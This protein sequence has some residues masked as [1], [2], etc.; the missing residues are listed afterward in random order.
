MKL[1]FVVLLSLCVAALATKGFDFSVWQGTPSVADLE[2]LKHNGYEFGIIQAQCSNGV[3]NSHVAQAFRNAK[4]AGIKYVDLYFFP[5]KSHDAASQVRNTVN[6]LKADG[7]HS[8]STQ[9]WIDIENTGLFF[10]S[11]SENVRFIRE[12]V[13]NLRKEWPGKIG[14]YTSESQWSPITCNSKDFADMQLWWPRYDGVGTLTH[15]WRSF[16]GW[17]RPAIKQYHNTM[18]ICGTQIDEDCY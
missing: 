18:S 14:I 12:I 15:N 6:H 9:M 4:A 8:S 2:C 13:D 16:G 17:S 10:P 7:L 3:Y 1:T 11:C 5:S